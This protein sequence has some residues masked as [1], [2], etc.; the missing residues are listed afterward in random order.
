MAADV[1]VDVPDLGKI[2]LDVSYGGNVYAVL[3]AAAAGRTSWA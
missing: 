2:R 3:P 1:G